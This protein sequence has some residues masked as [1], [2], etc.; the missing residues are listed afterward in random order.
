[1]QWLRWKQG[2]SYAGSADKRSVTTI[3]FEAYYCNCPSPPA[4]AVVRGIDTPPGFRIPL[5][6]WVGERTFA[7]LTR[8][9]CLG[10]EYDQRLRVSEA[11]IHVASGSSL[12][13]RTRHRRHSQTDS[14][15]TFTANTLSWHRHKDPEGL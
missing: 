4:I 14:A 11:M 5:Q 9:R 2:F 7:W 10:R 15:A 12:P 8:W 1:L 13:P 3:S 6:G